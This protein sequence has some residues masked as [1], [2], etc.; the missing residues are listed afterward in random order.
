MEVENF[1]TRF[2]LNSLWMWFFLLANVILFQIFFVGHIAPYAFSI[3]MYAGIN[4][5]LAVSLNL[6]NGFTGQF[7]MGHAGFMAVG[8]YTSAFLTGYF[9]LH[10]GESFSNPLISNSLFFLALVIGGLLS[11]GFGY[12]VGLPS[13]RLKGDYLA[14]VTLGFGEII[15]VLILNMDFL[16]AARGMPGIAGLSNFAWVY[17]LVVITIFFISRIIQS[18]HGRA[19][20]AVREDEIA[21]QAMGINVTQTKVRAF[22]IGSFFAGIA[23]G[24]FAHYLSFLSPAI[25]DFNKSFEIIIMVVLGGMGS[26]TGSF[27]AALFLTVLREALRGLQDITKVD[28][29]MVIYSLVLILLMLTRPNG[30]FGKKEFFDFLPRRIR[31]FFGRRGPAT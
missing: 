21:A 30:L 2:G 13:L 8:A 1:R 27:I 22:V 26:I 9:Q 14:I 24:L 17:G 15:R 25:F 3:V 5:I 31:H 12:I 11:A 18:A 28:L 23:G 20:M 10:L 19:L 6:V 16:G 7:S 4:I 29:R